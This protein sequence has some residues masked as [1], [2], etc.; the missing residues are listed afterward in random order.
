MQTAIFAAA[1]PMLA[2]YPAISETYQETNAEKTAAAML[3]SNVVSFG[4]IEGVMGVSYKTYIH[5]LKVG[6]AKCPPI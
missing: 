6:T 3:V 2:I 5:L 4:A 1:L